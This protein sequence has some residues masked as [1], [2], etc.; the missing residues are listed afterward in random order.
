MPKPVWL[1]AGPGRNLRERDKIREAL[2]GQPT[3]P[4]DELGA[5]IA[6]MRNRA[7]E[8]RQAQLEEDAKNLAETFGKAPAGVCVADQKE[9]RSSL[10]RAVLPCAFRP[11]LADAH[12]I[13]R[14]SHGPVLIV[15]PAGVASM[16]RLTAEA[17]AS[18]SPLPTS[19]TGHSR[20]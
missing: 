3:A 8:R 11:N 13:A 4:F 1:D 12:A 19:A 2:F 7:A 18:Q 10:T 15:A 17:N 14:G 16:A 20:P 9:E 5:K 6:K